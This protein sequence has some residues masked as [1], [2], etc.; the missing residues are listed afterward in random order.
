MIGRII[1]LTAISLVIGITIYSWNAQILAGNA[2]PMPFGYG[3]S[4][5]LSGSMEPTLSINDMVIVHEQDSYETGDIVV[6]QNGN[7]LV[8]HRIIDRKDPV[9]ITQ[10]DANNVADLPIQIR[11]IKGKAIAHIPLMGAVVRFLKT[12]IGT[13]LLVVAAALLFEMPYLR[14]RRKAEEDKEKIKEE[15]RKL[16]G[17]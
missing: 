15:I 6:Y 3:V 12:P 14:K 1:L 17:E 13:V 2:M 4:V 5:V 7:M 11:D 9:V 8:I 16:K 10:G